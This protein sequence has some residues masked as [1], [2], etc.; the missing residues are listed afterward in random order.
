VLK[1]KGNRSGDRAVSQWFGQVRDA[2]E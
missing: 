2:A 1:D